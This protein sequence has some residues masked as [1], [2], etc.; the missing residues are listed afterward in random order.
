MATTIRSERDFGIGLVYLALGIAGFALARNYAFGTPRQ[1]GPGFFPTI[2]SALLIVFG[3]AALVRG[4]LADGPPVG[5]WNL[6]GMVLITGSVLAFG[7]LLPVLG[8][9][10]AIFAST[11][12]A[13]TASE[14]FR[15][16]LKALAG[17]AVLSGVCSLVFVQLLRVPMPLVGSWLPFL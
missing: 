3:I 15:F 8:L 5:R 1:M 4:F 14:K 17:L 12:L 10:L 6:K 7:L 2:I 11:L 13:A 16:D 9:P